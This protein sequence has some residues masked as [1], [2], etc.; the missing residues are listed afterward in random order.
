[1]VVPIVDC[2]HP[3]GYC[4]FFYRFFHYMIQEST[5]RLQCLPL[6]RALGYRLLQRVV[7]TAYIVGVGVGVGV[8]RPVL[9][10]QIR[11]RQHSIGLKQ[12]VR[13]HVHS[14]LTFPA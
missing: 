1:M 6:P 2:L 13:T 4:M 11:S 5:D 3:I 7:K 14:M 8:F 12:T 9:F 10:M